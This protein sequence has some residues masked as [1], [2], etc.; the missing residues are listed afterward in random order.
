MREKMNDKEAKNLISERKKLRAESEKLRTKLWKTN[1]CSP[2]AERYR[3]RMKEIDS[4]F[5]E[6]G[7]LFDYA[8]A[9]ILTP[10]NANRDVTI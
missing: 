7:S 9:C 6:K 8:F 4:I 5:E 2:E 1:L 3:K 10:Q